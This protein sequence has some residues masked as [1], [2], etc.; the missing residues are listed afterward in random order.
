MG[1]TSGTTIG[2][3]P[4]DVHKTGPQGCIASHQTSPLPPPMPPAQPPEETYP[5]Y[6]CKYDYDARTDEE[7]C[8]RKGDLLYIINTKGDWWLAHSS[9]DGK[10][11]YSLQSRSR[12]KNHGSRRVS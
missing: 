6:I 3:T 12:L 5:V 8:F 4:T 9:K 10:E 1:N 11:G 2:T 7:L